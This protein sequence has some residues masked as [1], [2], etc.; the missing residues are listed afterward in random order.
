MQTVDQM[1]VDFAA[2]TSDQA[3]NRE[4]ARTQP[5]VQCRKFRLRLDYNALPAALVEPER[6]VIGNRMPCTDINIG[7]GGLS[8]KGQREMIVLEIL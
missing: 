4:I 3:A 7:P 8:R 6:D 5:L 2:V 1:E